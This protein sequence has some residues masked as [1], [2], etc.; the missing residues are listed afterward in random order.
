[1]ME[2]V[3]DSFSMGVIAKSTFAKFKIIV[4]ILCESKF[5]KRAGLAII[6]PYCMAYKKGDNRV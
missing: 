2:I 1:M 6:S 4:W 5:V 3:Y